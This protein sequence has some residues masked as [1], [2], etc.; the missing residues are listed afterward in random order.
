VNKA[1]AL[2]DAGESDRAL[3]ARVKQVLE[4]VSREQVDAVQHAAERQKDQ[5]FLERLEA[6]RLDRMIPYVDWKRV[7]AAYSSAFK[8]FGIDPD[9]LDPSEAGRLLSQRSTPSELAFYLDDWAL[10]RVYSGIG[11]KNDEPRLRLVTALR[12][13]DPDPLRNELRERRDGLGARVK[14]LANDD[15][16]LVSLPA[17]SLLLL[18][19][20]LD[21]VDESLAMRVLKR[22]WSLHPSDFWICYELG[23]MHDQRF[24]TAAV[25]LRPQNASTHFSLA[26]ALLP[27][28]MLE[29]WMIPDE[30]PFSTRE[31][32]D[33]AILEYRQAIRIRPEVIAFHDDLAHALFFKP[34]NRDEAIGHYRESIRLDPASLS[35]SQ[36][37]VKLAADL[38]KAGRYEEAIAVYRDYLRFDRTVDANDRQT[39]E[40]MLD[41]H[42]RAASRAQLLH[43]SGQLSQC[44]SALRD[45]IR[46]DPNDANSHNS[47]GYYLLELGE[48]ETAIREVRE[49]TRAE[50]NNP[51]F[52]DSLGW[53]EYSNGNLKDALINLR[54]ANR[55]QGGEP[56]ADIQAHL[57]L[58]ERLAD[59]EGQLDAILRGQKAPAD[60]ERRLDIAELCRVTHRF[61]A[62]AKFY[63]GAFQAKT[64]L[65]N[66]LASNHR[67]HAAVAAATAGTEGKTATNRPPHDDPERARWR[68][69]ALDWLRA[70]KDSC[71]QILSP[72]VPN[73]T[74][75]IAAVGTGLTKRSLARKTLDILTHHRDLARVWDDKE[76]AKLPELE[77][78]EWQEFWSDVAALL[79]KADGH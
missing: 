26:G 16:T 74:G 45:A 77:K 23:S 27:S 25:A 20:T 2:L 24:S 39:I 33:E 58:V 32:I 52:L 36:T 8:E 71:A 50:P 51:S 67:L 30:R 3:S 64:V 22:A 79:K 75:A 10:V 42:R 61:A 78:K 37:R 18:A 28:E 4:L 19:K 34:G 29:I 9:R 47:L 69:Q 21:G 1:Q 70:E 7:D 53:A 60:A 56:D 41:G 66:D 65:Q 6:V 57:N 55:L 46:L 54:E 31:N 15:R 5:R 14:D 44:L 35:G 76:L 13:A 63:G 62:A 68:T 73:T 40:L 48:I 59:L 43:F 17:Q 49:A 11:Q 12:A 38:Y 72:K